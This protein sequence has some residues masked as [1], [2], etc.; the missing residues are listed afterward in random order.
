MTL[1]NNALGR[2]RLCAW[3]EGTTY[4]LLGITMPLKYW[5]DMP[6]PNYIVGMLHGVFFILYCLLV[7][8]V[9][10]KDKW[11]KINTFW[12]LLASLIPFG[13]FVAEYKLF[14]Y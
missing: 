6:Q 14:R 2:L 10:F 1:L 13:T 11:S 3:I 12:A 8:Q 5:M 4:L 7:L 9:A